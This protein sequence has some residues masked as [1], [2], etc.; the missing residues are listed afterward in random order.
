AWATAIVTAILFFAAIIAH[1]IAHALV[2]R[3]R[4][5]PVRSITLFALGGVAQIEKE[6]A[7][8][9]TEFWMGIAGPI[10]SAVAGFLCLGLARTLGWVALAEPG[11]PLMAMLVWLGYINIALAI[12]NMVPGFPMDGGRVLRAAIWAITGNGDRATRIASLTGQFIAVGF[13][14]LGVVSFFR[15]GALDGLWIAFIGWFLLEAARASYAQL[16]MRGRLR[17]VRTSDV[18]AND[19]PLVDGRSNLQSFVDDHLL[20]TGRRYFL[21]SENGV[22]TGLM[23]P[24]EVT[25]IDRERWPRVTVGEAMIPIERLGIVRPDTP[26]S[27]TLEVIARANVNQVPVVSNGKFEGVVSRGRI[28]EVAVTRAE[29]DM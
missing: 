13:I 1:E 28:L 22:V 9:R 25:A 27:E 21:I 4:G 17:G 20:P 7:D 24:R 11:T 10:A 16:E 12:F 14:I 19:Y 26:V 15:V 18:M 29:L 5:L 3:M 2:A 23:T 6:A 8:P